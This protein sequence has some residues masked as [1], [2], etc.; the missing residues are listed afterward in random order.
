MGGWVVVNGNGVV[1]FS[2]VVYYVLV[3]VCLACLFKLYG[4]RGWK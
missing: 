3:V 1:L 2:V 4:T